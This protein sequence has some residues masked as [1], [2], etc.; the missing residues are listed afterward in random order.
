MWAAVSSSC[1]ERGG[2]YTV[3]TLPWCDHGIFHSLKHLDS[4]HEASALDGHW[5]PREGSTVLAWMSWSGVCVCRSLSPL[6]ASF[7]RGSVSALGWA[8]E[9]CSSQFMPS[10][11]GNLTVLWE[12]GQHREKRGL[13]FCSCYPA[14]DLASQERHL[15]LGVR[16]PGSLSHRCAGK[17][18][19][20]EVLSSHL[21]FGLFL[22][23]CLSFPP[24]SL[25]V[26]NKRPSFYCKRKPQRCL[27]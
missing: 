7:P 17:G 24:S 12:Q 26:S 18:G 21:Y 6:F 5:N 20:W 22:W 27:L 10:D 3:R 19:H 16:A 11:W 25:L 15:A 4:V 14:K 8:P 23:V 2:T 13:W 1:L 9:R